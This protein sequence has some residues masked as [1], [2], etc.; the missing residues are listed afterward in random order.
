MVHFASGK[1]MNFQNRVLAA[2]VSLLTCPDACLDAAMA[3]CDK[4]FN[5]T[6]LYGTVKPRVAVR[7]V[8]GVTPLREWVHQMRSGGALAC[9]LDIA[10]HDNGDVPAHTMGG[11]EAGRPATLEVLHAGRSDTYSAAPSRV[12]SM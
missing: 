8:P 4:M 7:T 1:A 6:A 11:F 5:A 3:Q 2:T 9:R 12:R 10:G